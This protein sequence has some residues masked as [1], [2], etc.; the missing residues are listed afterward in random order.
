MDDGSTPPRDHH[1]CVSE[2]AKE[3]LA[4]VSVGLTIAEC[5]SGR[6]LI[7]EAVPDEAHIKGG[8]FSEAIQHCAPDA[9]LTTNTLNLTLQD[10]CDHMPD[11]SWHSRM[12]GL[13]F[14][15]PVMFVPM[16]EITYRPGA[17]DHA[18]ERLSHMMEA[19]EKMVF[20]ALFFR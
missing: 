6:N 20:G 7:I 18:M 3:A 2:G 15:S 12:L 10:I 5:V 13:R 9:L 16:C 14:L 4:K 11:A 1:N 8:V 19:M 17:Q